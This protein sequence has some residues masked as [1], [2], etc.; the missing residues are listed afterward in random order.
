M[1]RAF[2]PSNAHSALTPM[3]D[4]DATVDSQSCLSSSTTSIFQLGRIMSSS[5]TSAFSRS[6]VTENSVPCPCRLLT[7]MEPPMASTTINLVMA[8][9]SP[10][11]SVR[12]TRA[13][14]SRAKES[15]MCSINWLDIPMPVSFTCIWM[16]TKFAPLG[17]SS[18]YRAM[19]ISPPSGVNLMALDSRFSSTWLSRTLSHSTFS[20]EIS[21][22]NTSNCCFLAFT[23]GWQMD[24]M[25]STT[26]RRDT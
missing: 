15:K 2:S 14:S 12:W 24:T 5:I 26:S 9:P 10:V 16:R 11:P 21:W 17:D 6:S 23:W 13:L 3:E 4:R 22:M 18:S 20:V 7:S 25:P 8:M 1:D 19:W